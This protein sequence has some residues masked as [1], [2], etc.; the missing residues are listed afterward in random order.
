MEATRL[1]AGAELELVVVDNGSS[2]GT[3]ALVAQFPRAKAVVTPAPLGFAEANDAARAVARGE[4]VVFLNNDTEPD[5]G[6][7][8][9]PLELLAADPRVVAVGSKLLFMHRYLPVRVT[10][11]E[12]SAAFVASEVYGDALDS[13]VRW[14]PGAPAEALHRGARGRWIADATVYVPEP[15]P[16]LD[17]PWRAPAL[18]VLAHRGRAQPVT[19]RAGGAPR[20]LREAPGVFPLDPS[21]A[22]VSLVQNAGSV[23]TAEGEGGDHGTGWPDG[24]RFAR[25]EVVPALCGAAVTVRRREL[26]AA[27]WFP[28]YYTMYYEDT[29]LMLR[30]R[31]RGLLVFAPDSVVRHYHTGTTRERSPEFVRHVVRSGILFTARHAPR[32]V[33]AG[34]LARRVWQ[35]GREVRAGGLRAAFHAP[36]TRGVA[37]ALAALPG[38]ILE[39]LR[40]PEPPAELAIPRAPYTAPGAQD[41]VAG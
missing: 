33:A 16:G 4:V 17:A 1:P 12:G 20:T 23:V 15:I 31:R 38:V 5:P 2:D 18:R 13:K 29:D 6:W 27:G 28:R 14:E 37:G 19:V 10:A 9:R 30:L 7:L 39:R 22:R 26:D 32:R 35:A 24:P 3:S 25:E 36:I 8:L 41:R 21:G 40:D 34:A 11:G